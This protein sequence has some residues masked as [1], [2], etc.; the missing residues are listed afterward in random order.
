MPRKYLLLLTTV[1]L[2]T[3]TI[4]PGCKGTGEP[5]P[6]PAPKPSPSP[7]PEPSST[8]T[9]LS[10]QITGLN[11]ASPSSLAGIL[12][13]AQDIETARAEGTV[14]GAE[15]G[16][17]ENE[18]KSKF[19]S[20]TRETV[21]GIDPAKPESIKDFFDLQA[22]QRTG[23]YD[24]LV[25]PATKEY[26]EEQMTDKFNQ[27]VRNRVD[28]IDP[29]DEGAL[30]DMFDL[31]VIQR[32]A[33]YDELATTDTQEY[34][35][36]QMGR[37]LNEWVRNQV[38]DIDPTDPDNL[39]YFFWMQRA[40]ATE[41]Y[42]RFATPE[43]HDYKERQ[44]KQ[45]FNEWVENCVNDLDP[46]DPDF[47]E[48]LEMLRAIQLSDK[49]DKFIVE[50]V[51]QW[52]ERT[53]KQKM[54]EYIAD[55]VDNLDPS[56]PTFW[57]DL[58]RLIEFQLSDVY[59]DLCAKG[60]K[61]YKQAQLAALLTKPLG[62]PPMIAGV[63]PTIGQTDVP[64]DQ[65][66]MIVFEQPMEPGSL[67]EAIEV[68]PGTTFDTIPMVE[69]NFIILLK[70]LEPLAENATYNITVSQQAVSLA[71]IPLLETYEFSFETRAAGPAPNI[72][73]TSPADGTIDDKA[74]QPVIITF[75]QRMAT[76]SVESA[77]SISP[78]FDYSVVWTDGNTQAILQSHAPLDSNT[79]YGITIGT[80]AMSGDGIPLEKDY[81]F[82]FTPVIMNLPHV[83]GTLP[84]S[85]QGGV[86]SNHP[87]QIVFDRSM[88]TAS[89]EARLNVSPDFTYDTR[90]YE[91]D[92]VLQIEPLAPL[93]ASQ[94]YAITV[95]TGALSSFGL[96]LEADYELVFT[97]RE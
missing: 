52:K 64:L 86:P 73:A 91:A 27:W 93:L 41:K 36:E 63:Y 90:W 21:D 25:D 26:K 55:I 62:P 16:K 48:K 97:T 17:L 83:M 82:S 84:D 11:P 31:Q 51:H 61:E 72:I 74:G 14:S 34:K 35:E 23:E 37:K 46:D 4:I 32:T 39:K 2:I 7:S 1:L 43:T 96:P 44:M 85:G 76:S 67:K 71:G 8:Y 38:D 3:F 69:E 29:E 57:E 40:Q 59:D 87:I 49:Y 65:S 12:G 53:L 5:I 80:G 68:L 54:D 10:D 28:E 75:D 47:L 42:D 94:Q 88:D 58:A 56:S 45:K 60:T 50:S 22:V 33:K 77:I 15:A 24:E 9:S 70:P 66:I 92:M 19:S 89:V 95:G 6:E 20:W 30:K 13:A 81:S 78:A 79:I 18:L